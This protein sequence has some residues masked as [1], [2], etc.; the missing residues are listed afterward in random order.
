VPA[1]LEP[2]AAQESVEL[3]KR[4]VGPRFEVQP[5]PRIRGGIH[6]KLNDEV[7]RSRSIMSGSTG[8]KVAGHEGLGS[9]PPA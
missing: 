8:D 2:H 7:L 1:T 6:A 3:V 9:L 4:G 5:I